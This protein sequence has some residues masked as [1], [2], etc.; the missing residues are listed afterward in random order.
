MKTA[1]GSAMTVLL[2]IVGLLVAVAIAAFTSYVSAHNFGNQQEKLLQ[3]KLN[4][5]KNILGQYTIK[6]GEMAQIPE[7]YRDDLR[8]VIEATFQGRYGEEGSRATFQ[9]IQEQ[10][11]TF[12]SSLYDRLQQTMEAGRNEFKTSQ[13]ELLDAKRVYETE[14]GS[15]W[16]GMWLR[17]AG[18]PKIDLDS[19]KIVVASDTEQKFESGVDEGIRLRQAE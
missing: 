4:D 9:W 13:T 14:L 6:I 19:I 18:Y 16:S 17:I 8:E 11:P 15:F 10:N 12:D 7:M 5:N 2:V 1:R 3:A